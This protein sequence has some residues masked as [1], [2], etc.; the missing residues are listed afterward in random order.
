MSWQKVCG[1]KEKGTKGEIM[2]H[3]CRK[4]REEKQKQKD[5]WK[6]KVKELLKKR[7]ARDPLRIKT[8]KKTYDYFLEKLPIISAYKDFWIRLPEEW[9]AKSH[10]E[11]R[12]LMS[13]L[14]WLFCVYKPPEFLFKVFVKKYPYSSSDYEQY[15]D[16]F[17]SWFIEIGQGYSFQKVAASVLT[18]KEAHLFLKP[19]KLIVTCPIE[20]V[21]IHIM[22]IK[23]K[24]RNLPEPICD[25]LA[26]KFSDFTIRFSNKAAYQ[27]QRGLFFTKYFLDFLALYLKDPLLTKETIENLLDYLTRLTYDE[28]GK[29]SFKGRTLNSVIQLSNQWHYQQTQLKEVKVTKWAGLPIEN[30]KYVDNNNIE[31]GITQLKTSSALINEGR[32]QHHCVGS[33]IDR[34]INGQSNIFTMENDIDNKIATIEVDS[35]HTI[36]QISGSC[37]KKITGTNRKMI[38]RWA[39]E[40][41][42]KFQ[43]WV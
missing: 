19:P 43:S 33:Y 21:K 37:N 27:A 23:C 26:N 40:C 22:Y 6:E 29:F 30:F 11:D 3:P 14:M 13:F 39:K 8:K 28:I 5:L 18:K 7:D 15:K 34:C 4:Q 31:W 12:Q 1:I 2:A 10:N 42:L 16:L 9:V 20:T 41:N 25:L 38:E 17:I 36:V 24:V 35:N 32:K